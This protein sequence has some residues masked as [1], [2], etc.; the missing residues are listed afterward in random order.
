MLVGR[1]CNLCVTA[2]LSSGSKEQETGV[3]IKKKEVLLALW[4][5]KQRCTMEGGKVSLK[6]YTKINHISE[7]GYGLWIT[8]YSRYQ[9]CISVDGK[10]HWGTI[11]QRT[12]SCT[13][14]GHW[15]VADGNTDELPTCWQK[16]EAA[17]HQ[18]I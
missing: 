15:G 4:E 2:E 8:K 10:T 7:G 18:G 11:M 3:G 12:K 14:A 13:G 5:Q 17:R 9:K 16:T 6:K 1:C